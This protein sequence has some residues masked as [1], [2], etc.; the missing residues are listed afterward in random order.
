[1]ERLAETRARRA[2]RAADRRQQRRD[3]DR[4]RF[5]DTSFDEWR[6]IVSINLM[7]VVY[8]SRLFGRAMLEQGEGG[9]IVN[10]ASAAAFAPSRVAAG[11]LDHE[12]RGADAERVPAGRARAVRGSA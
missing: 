10:T 11:L 7:G 5:L 4:R 1:M 12:G 3:R 6:R 8:G 2:R 9:Q